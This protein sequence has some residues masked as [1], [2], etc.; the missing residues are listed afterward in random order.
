M[1]C[2]LCHKT[3]NLDDPEPVVLAYSR[4][5][6]SCL[7][8]IQP[9]PLYPRLFESCSVPLS[10]VDYRGQGG[11]IVRDLK[12]HGKRRLLGLWVYLLSQAYARSL[13]VHPP[14]QDRYSPI[15]VPVPPSQYGLWYRGWDPVAKG[16][17]QFALCHGFEIGFPIKRCSGSS[18]KLLSRKQRMDGSIVFQMRS[19]QGIPHTCTEVVLIDDVVTTGAT[20]GQITRLI[21]SEYPVSV[22]CISIAQD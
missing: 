18:Q 19:A 13:E 8:S 17:Q 22:R 15:V 21:T 1:R 14:G 11:Q 16:A 10:A 2:L 4:T 6:R 3:L 12:F 9:Y 20:M 7:D 5:C